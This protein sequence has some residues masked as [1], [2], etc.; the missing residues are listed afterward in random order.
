MAMRLTQ[1][2]IR[3]GQVAGGALAVVDGPHR[4]TWNETIERIA[5]LAAGMR[6]LGL[7][8]GDRAAILS[9]NSHRYFEFLYGA[10][11]G[12]GAA[13]PI[14]I[15]LAPP[16]ID[17][18]L[19]DSGAKLLLI[20]DTFLP[21]LPK[22]ASVK[23]LEAVIYLGDGAAPQGLLP[24]EAVI[25]ESDPM[26]DA[27]VKGDD[28]AG[29]YYTGGTTGM[30]KGVMLSHANLVANAMN[31][32]IALAYTRA[33]T[34]AHAAPMFHLADGCSS[35]S[36]TM[37]GGRHV[38][39]PRFDPAHFL[40][41]VAAE[42]ITDTTL[43][44][45]MVRMLV[46]HPELPKTDISSLRRIYYGAAPMPTGVIRKAVSLLPGIKLQ[47]AWGMTELSP[48]GCTIEPEYTTLE[49]PLAG[50]VA[51]CGRPLTSVELRIV[52]EHGAEVP[53]G[54]VGEIAVRGP[55]VMLGYWNKPEETA[56]A[57]RDGWMH[58]G[59][60]AYMDEEG[61][62]F[63]V[64]R[65]KDMIVSGGENIYTAEVESAISLIDGVAECAV[66][67]VPDETYGEVVHAIVVA[68]PGAQLG[69][70][71]IMA[72]CRDRIA[73]YKCPRSVTIRAEPLPLSGAGK[74]LKTELRAPF[75]KGRTSRIV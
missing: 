74:V 49:G 60:A 35:F 20:D 75:W 33:C 69:A 11:W 64:D 10:V 54:V 57:L 32:I 1:G 25:A 67:G 23:A 43:V 55:T 13:V 31:V 30:A 42:R 6:F 51:S 15:R 56:K 16:E 73:G 8:R 36:I 59:D 48:I 53:R 46:D 12:G 65:L 50:R 52:D 66:I 2:L 58:S 4:R 34:Y 39:L 28:L 70:E 24:Y 21:L 9:L 22:L 17:Y 44:P 68:K 63:I 72:G 27:D 19:Q 45:T 40:K 41:L 7:Q 14:N 62:V 61:F 18:I 47:Q 5:R 38:F 26:A 3:A 29:I 71:A 37:L